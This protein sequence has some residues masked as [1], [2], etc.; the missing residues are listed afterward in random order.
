V[1]LGLFLF[2]SSS[3]LLN[4]GVA[5]SLFS[6]SSKGRVYCVHY[7]LQFYLSILFTLLLPVLPSFL[8]KSRDTCSLNIWFRGFKKCWE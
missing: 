7:C 5:V 3:T 1:H 2:Q 6:P 4:P 8:R